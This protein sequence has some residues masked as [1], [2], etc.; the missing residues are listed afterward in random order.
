MA[1]VPRNE[2]SLIALVTILK[3]NVVGSTGLWWL[4]QVDSTARFGFG[5]L[6][7]KRL[8]VS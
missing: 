6:I 7:F 1:E 5:T 4:N 2:N 8:F 3:P